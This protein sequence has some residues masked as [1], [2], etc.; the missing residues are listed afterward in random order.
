MNILGDREK[1][2]PLRTTLNC[3]INR[4]RKHE[5][6]LD[7]SITA[8]QSGWRHADT[9]HRRFAFAALI[10]LYPVAADLESPAFNEQCAAVVAIGIFSVGTRH[11]T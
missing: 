7:F 2:L 4:E 6:G 5:T 3:D 8:T 10:V 11:V 9:C 1:Q